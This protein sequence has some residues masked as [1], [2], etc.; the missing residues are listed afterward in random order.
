MLIV[1]CI[2]YTGDPYV[3]MTPD[4]AG[5]LMHQALAGKRDETSGH[6]P[7]FQLVG[8]SASP[9][10]SSINNNNSSSDGSTRS[11]STAS[12]GGGTA[13]SNSSGMEGSSHR[14]SG[15]GGTASTEGGTAG[16]S[17][18]GDKASSSGGAGTGSGGTD[19]EDQDNPPPGEGSSSKDGSTAT[20]GHTLRELVCPIEMRDTPAQCLC[21]QNGSWCMDGAAGCTEKQCKELELSS[22][23]CRSHVVNH[24]VWAGPSLFATVTSQ[25]CI[26]EHKTVLVKHEF[27]AQMR[28]CLL[29]Q[30]C[31]TGSSL[32][33]IETS[34]KTKHVSSG[35]IFGQSWKVL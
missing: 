21:C 4:D 7:G 6:S 35:K 11:G 9:R 27:G 2:G 15:G 31:M 20:A 17:D 32:T 19:G 28:S 34:S 16:S 10:N 13:G 1:V 30:V 24:T 25:L 14:S 33:G 29:L 22:S 12:W 23:N 8:S 3:S 18:S 5:A 26:P